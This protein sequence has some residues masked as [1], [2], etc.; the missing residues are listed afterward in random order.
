M[1]GLA[2]SE[3][4]YRDTD[5]EYYLKH[6][7][8]WLPRR[9]LD[10]HMHVHLDKHMPDLTQELIVK[11]WATSVSYPEYSAEMADADYRK[12]F[13]DT[14]MSRLQ[15]G[16]V[17]READYEACNDY[18]SATADHERIWPLCVIAPQSTGEQLKER[19]TKGR[20]L[21]VKPYWAMVPGK[22]EAEVG[23][24]EMVTP[25]QLEALDELGMIA[26]LHVPGPER[27]RD[28]HSRAVLRDWCAKYTRAKFVVAHLGR[29]YS[30]PFAEAS[31]ADLASID[32]LLFDCCAFLNP[33]GFELAFNTIGPERI[34]WGTDF[35]VLNR[36]RG[37]R[38]WD[39]ETYKNYT[40]GDFPWNTD[41]RP[42]GV[43][44]AYT[45]F[46]YVA[47]K[48]LK[49]GAER[50]GLTANELS[51]VFF[52]NAHRLVTGVG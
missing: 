11:N 30:Y 2:V 25:E 10:V 8:G 29:A 26:V 34:M 16:T 35:P 45:Y 47:L 7:D 48:A 41:R 42:P 5:R 3:L 19:L 6:L 50:A 22:K 52:G 14:E 39:G 21:G 20:F 23:L 15:F 18:I 31:F 27:I 4:E 32:G 13:P 37:Y 17:Y 36:M 49:D 1:S 44:A 51:E 24:D 12:L 43:E 46:I 33:D 40:S 28:E 38:V 9:M